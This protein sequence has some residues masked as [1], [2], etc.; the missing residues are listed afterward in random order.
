LD[1]ASLP[2]LA[3]A[4]LHE[5]RSRLQARQYTALQAVRQSIYFQASYAQELLFLDQQAQRRAS[6]Q[7]ATEARETL[8]E[9]LGEEL[10]RTLK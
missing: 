1:V 2:D 5:E 4:C 7:Q 9:K 3:Q 10:A 8:N 6:L